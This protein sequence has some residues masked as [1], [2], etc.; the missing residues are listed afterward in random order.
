MKQRVVASIS[1]SNLHMHRFINDEEKIQYA[2]FLLYTV[3]LIQVQAARSCNNFIR[4]MPIR[5]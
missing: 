5:P 1:S 2:D 3:F 4:Y